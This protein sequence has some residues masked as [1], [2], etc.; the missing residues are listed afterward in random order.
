MSERT[1]LSRSNDCSLFDLYAK[2]YCVALS[3][4][5][6]WIRE[7]RLTSDLL[8]TSPFQFKPTYTLLFVFFVNM[9]DD[10][11]VQE[12]VTCIEYLL[13]IMRFTHSWKAS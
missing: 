8:V 13:L 10:S 9:I 3:I 5:F 1:G 4:R 2:I 12:L 6:L 7:D 11:V